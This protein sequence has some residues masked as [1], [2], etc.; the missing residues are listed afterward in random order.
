[1]IIKLLYEDQSR[2]FKFREE[3]V[4][5]RLLVRHIITLLSLSAGE[6]LLF[7]KS[8]EAAEYVPLT[9]ELLS[10]L[11]NTSEAHQVIEVQARLPEPSMA[12]P[13]EDSISIEEQSNSFMSNEMLQKFKRTLFGER[14]LD[15][16]QEDHSLS[17]NSISQ[18]SNQ[19][20][21]KIGKIP[22][23][24]RN[25]LTEDLG[26]SI[27]EEDYDDDIFS[28]LSGDTAKD[29]LSIIS[30]RQKCA[31]DFNRSS[32][33]NSLEEEDSKIR[34]DFKK[35]EEGLQE[36][37]E[38]YELRL[39]NI[40]GNLHSIDR[41]VNQILT[42]V[43]R[44]FTLE[45]SL[46]SSSCRYNCAC[47]RSHYTGEFCNKTQ[48]DF[49]FT[50]FGSSYNRSESNDTDNSISSQETTRK[51]PHSLS[52]TAKKSNFSFSRV[53]DWSVNAIKKVWPKKKRFSILSKPEKKRSGDQDQ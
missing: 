29:E 36:C 48:D 53:R 30:A 35:L 3:L 45:E 8:G 49:E 52:K 18:V 7:V 21:N 19:S 16:S 28:K 20:Y 41:K 44:G 40:E 37:R 23:L 11:F 5:L 10:E 27:I 1:M 46:E 2:R 31:V 9:Q 26:I 25:Y 42:L 51:R 6:L 13:R 34:N 50:S 47:G 4:D 22:H 32:V 39:G 24:P 43:D 12:E 33:S 38:E 15:S 17:L 14:V